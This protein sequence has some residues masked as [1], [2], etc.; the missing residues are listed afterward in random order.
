MHGLRPHRWQG[1]TNG[2][3]R[4]EKSNVLPS[5]ERVNCSVCFE[6]GRLAVERMDRTLLD[7]CFRVQGR[8][9]WYLEPQEIQ[10]DLATF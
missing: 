5:H 9:T 3:T 1:I 2:N 7:E 8:Q 6:A 4:S 10:R